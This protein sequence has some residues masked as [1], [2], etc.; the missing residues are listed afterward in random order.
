MLSGS[1]RVRSTWRMSVCKRAG[2]VGVI[3]SAFAAYSAAQEPPPSVGGP[4]TQADESGS[5][6][7]NESR[8]PNSDIVL[9]VA[10]ALGLVAV[11]VFGVCFVQRYRRRHDNHTLEV[12]TELVKDGDAIAYRVMPFGGH[13]RFWDKVANEMTTRLGIAGTVDKHIYIDVRP[14]PGERTCNVITRFAC[15]AAAG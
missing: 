2:V 1:I 15:V 4:A 8:T 3:L 14:D 9:Y 11:L 6:D 7:D 5:P 10:I 12:P 13:K